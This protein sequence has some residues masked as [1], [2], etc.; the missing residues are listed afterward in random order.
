MKETEKRGI[1]IAIIIN[2]IKITRKEA[3]SVVN[4]PPHQYNL[5]NR[6]SP[7]R[8]EQHRLETRGRRNIN[9]HRQNDEDS[10]DVATEAEQQ[11][12]PQILTETTVTMKRCI[13]S[14]R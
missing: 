2:A 6:D 5:R 9:Q 14:I 8:E 11:Q 3:I 12:V 10:V 4:I 7:R 13:M 1:T